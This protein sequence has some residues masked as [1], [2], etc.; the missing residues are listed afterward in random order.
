MP[1]GFLPKKVEAQSFGAYT[2]G[3]APAIAALPQCQEIINSGINDLFSGIGSGL[4]DGLG[5]F[6][7]EHNADIEKRLLE[8][9][10]ETLTTDFESIQV[11]DPTNTEK[12]NE[13]KAKID[14]IE[15]STASLNANS[16]C[17][18]SIGRLIIKM[19]L[20][21]LT[22]STV[23]WI[24]S[25]FDGSPAFIQNPGKFFNDI[26]KNEIL[27]F[28][29]EINNPELFPFGKA[30]MQNTATAFNNKFQDNARYSLNELIQNTNPEYSAKTFQL[31]FSQGGWDAWTAMTQSPANNPIGFKIMAD[32]EIQSR[33][34]G[35]VQSTAENVHEAL[36]QANGFLGDM[37][38]S[39][40]SKMTQTDVDAALEAGEEDPCKARGGNWE[41]VTP[42]KMISDAATNVID[43][44]NNS[45]LNVEDLNDSVAAVLDALLA[46]FSS[47]IME[48]GFANIGNDGSNGNL[49]FDT[50]GSTEKYRS[51]TEKDFMPSQL[52][53]SWLK[54][55][56]NFDIRTDLTQAL[57]DE[58]RTYSDKL[59]E[60]NKELFST[61]DGKNYA[62][63]TDKNS[64]TYGQ[65]NAY[66]LIPLISQL[67]YCIPGPHPGW[68]NDSRKVLAAVTDTIL[69]ETEN[70]LKNISEDKV[71]GLVQ[72]LLPMAGAA[73]GATVIAGWLGGAALGATLGSAVPIVGTIIGAALGVV[74]GYITS[75][76][77]DD[78]DADARKVR[79]YYSSIIKAFT[80]ILAD[81]GSPNRSA[82]LNI[83]SK[84]GVVNVLNRILD[85]YIEIMNDTYFSNKSELLPEAA[86]AA[87]LN[88]NRLT[89]YG[90]MVKNNEDKIVQIKS[91]VN[92]LGQIK[93]EVNNLNKKYPDGGENYE[94]ELK[95][96]ID[97][98][99]RLSMNMVN[100]NDIASADDLLQ[101][102][103]DKKDDIYKNLLK[104]PY[105]C[106]KSLAESEQK[107]F[108]ISKD[109]KTYTYSADRYATPSREETKEIVSKTPWIGYN[110][111]SVKRM[112]YPFPILYDY[113]LYENGSD[114][115]DPWTKEG[116]VGFKN[117]MPETTEVETNDKL[118]PG[119]LSFVLFQGSNFSDFPDR[120]LIGD[121]IPLKIH[122]GKGSTGNDEEEAFRGN[123][124]RALGT[125]IYGKYQSGQ[126]ESIIGIY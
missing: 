109:Y 61:T 23:N 91:I 28:G 116:E 115:P 22:V 51:K 6:Y 15:T 103:K 49:V 90:Q 105:G 21:K 100:G 59:E 94:N 46:Q 2:S 45:Y 1:L 124:K 69:P 89:G 14:K 92:I 10:A 110:V 87:A 39:V 113:N 75:L 18:Q 123:I 31:D 17:I 56:P 97:T 84:G 67:D 86:K 38:C 122:D 88:F 70:S 65:S 40:D 107:G 34:Q 112:T 25:G 98:F 43:Y 42:G 57:I 11:N 44:P 30:W 111:L 96:Q 8:Q 79:I 3:L 16:T 125:N 106:E 63:N 33:L 48:K 72:S 120:L 81:Y 82:A 13:I 71:G 85:R 102:I 64:A 41:Y 73:V 117:K 7:A 108:T 58:Q 36:S 95:L 119:F 9:E 37:R 104:G 5:D 4:T 26:A 121:L 77:S 52:S 32:N 24:N 78:S 60:Q 12:L 35:T 27:Q 83:S 54:A 80:G 66:G 76:F 20:Q 126:F 101:Q 50:S 47:N 99:G 93:E 74:I 62:I 53:S 55:N 19:L 114:I 29:A 68:E 118:G